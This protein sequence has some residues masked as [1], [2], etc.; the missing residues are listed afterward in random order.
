[1]NTETELLVRTS[2]PPR[3]RVGRRLRELFHHREVLVNL[4]R[5]ETKVK[6]KSSVLG[7]AWSMLNP[8]LYLAVFYVVFTFFLRS[9]ISNFVVY[10]LAGIVPWTLFATGLQG[11]TGSVVANGPLVTKVAF[12]REIL[13]LSA[14]GAA[15]VNFGYQSLVLVAA[16][17]V[18][19]YPF[20]GPALV[21]VPL[22]LVVLLLF[23]TAVGLSTSA[24][25]V[26]YRDT[27][28]LVDLALL[29]WFW[30][31]PIVYQGPKVVAEN[32]GAR[33]LQLYLLNPLANVVLAFQRALYGGSSA[34]ALS[35]LPDPGI[36]WYAGRL[37]ALGAVSILL[38]YVTWR[39]FYRMSGDFAEEL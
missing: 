7:V 13:P 15:V 17:L 18:F 16:L 2:E 8:V 22:A 5:K 14:I 19:T 34:E 37:G 24:F 11:A 9:G 4:I 3:L 30:V 32:L 6:Y 39:A 31:T 28:H 33:A 21:L 29:A 20:L 35:E 1:M 27:H 10:L 12:P 36:A 23:L 38:L 26:R 25:N